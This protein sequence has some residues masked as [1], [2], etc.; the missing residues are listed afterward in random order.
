M[1]PL[2]N[3]EITTFQRCEREWQHRY[4]DHREGEGITESL[5]RGKRIHKELAAWWSGA[6]TT[7]ELP[8]IE[9]AM[10]IGYAARYVRPNLRD[11]RVNVPFRCQ[12]GGVDVVGECDAVGVYEN[13]R[14]VVVEHKTTTQNISPGSQYWRE[15]IHCDTQVSTYLAAFPGATVLYDVLHTPGLKVLGVNK[16]RSVPES[17]EEYIDRILADMTREPEKYFQRAYI[18]RLESE[19]E[20]FADD[21]VAV[22]SRMVDTVRTVNPPRNP[23]SCFTYGRACDFFDVCYGGKAI[24]DMPLVEKNHSEDVFERYKASV[25]VENGHKSLAVLQE[26]ASQ[27]A[28]VAP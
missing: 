13:G 2:T 20:S 22:S 6:K 26:Y 8:P 4:L 9:T 3:S 21:L 19:H 28:T 16:S 5:S 17:N 1:S 10:M 12:I 25:A 23:R 14:T 27:K 24:T 11:V 15:R 18:V 7:D